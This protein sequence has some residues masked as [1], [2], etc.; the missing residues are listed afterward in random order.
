HLPV[1]CAK[2]GFHYLDHG[3]IMLPEAGLAIVGSMNWYDYSW[4]IDELPKY[5]VHWEERLRRKL[6]TRGIHNDARFVRWQFSD[7]TFT[8]HVVAALERN[9]EDALRQVPK[10]IVVTHHPAFF[11][12]NFPPS[13]PPHLDQLLWQ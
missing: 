11:G 9:L 1:V 12:L 8:A 5:D 6:F 3:P 7:I 10:A 4:S 2:Y 13:K